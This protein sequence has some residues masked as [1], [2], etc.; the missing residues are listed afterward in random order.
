MP[1]LKG[2]AQMRLGKVYSVNFVYDA[3]QDKMNWV[4]QSVRAAVGA[5]VVYQVFF[6]AISGGGIRSGEL[7]V[8]GF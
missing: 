7:I 2:V 3:K 4:V 8:G 1:S 6:D 5:G